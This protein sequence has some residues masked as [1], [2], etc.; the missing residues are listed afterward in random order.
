MKNNTLPLIL[1]VGF[2]MMLYFSWSNIMNY[3]KT[4]EQQYS[5]CLESAEFYESREIYVDAIT[6]YEAALKLKPDDHET[7]VKLISLYD[8]MKNDSGY[9]TACDKAFAA[10][11]KDYQ[12]CL[13]KV[14]RLLIM[15]E[16]SKAN[17]ALKDLKNH[18]AAD[19]DAPQ[20]VCDR[21]EAIING[22]RSAYSLISC[23][24]DEF[25][26]FVR[27]NS[28]EIGQAKVR[29]GQRYGIMNAT[30]QLAFKCEYDDINITNGTLT[31]MK[32]EQGKY[33]FYDNDGNLRVVTDKPAEYLGVFIN[34]Y[35][36]AKIDGVYGYINQTMQSFHF[37]YEYAGNFGGG[38]AP[39]KKDGKWAIINESFEPVTQFEFDE[40]L[41]DNYGF[42]TQFG[43]FFAK[44]NGVL[45]LYNNTGLLIA[46]GFEDVKLFAS[47]QPAAV[48]KDG[49]WGFIQKD[50]TMFIEPYYADADSFSVSLAPV[51]Q[52]GQ[53]KWGVIDTQNRE[54]I[55]PTFDEMQAFNGAGYSYVVADGVQQFV[56]MNSY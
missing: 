55:P 4:T 52:P 39:V 19:A 16:K 50:G 22:L 43:V 28:A 8:T 49:K 21:V 29:L 18:L 35:A 36:T 27:L 46:E 5:Q 7:A 26:G 20:E 13:L 23:P 37:E 25:Y 3:N 2:G 31:A 33:R 1:L 34:G 30:G 45:G 38:V 15:S 12:S 42:G 41:V 54:L 17:D 11:P 10:D 24:V 48:K 47:D 40:I 14:E 9:L 44:K 51:V 56:S 6:Q 53:E 32:D